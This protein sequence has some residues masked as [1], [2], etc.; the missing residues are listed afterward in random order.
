MN[1]YRLQPLLEP[2]PWSGAAQRGEALVGHGNFPLPERFGA[3]GAK[4]IINVFVG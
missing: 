2:A 1:T 4:I 3:T